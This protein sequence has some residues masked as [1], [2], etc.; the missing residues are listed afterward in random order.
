MKKLLTL[1]LCVLLM[2]ALAA[3]G[4]AGSGAEDEE[5]A[6]ATATDLETAEEYVADPAETADNE[7]YLTDYAEAAGRL[8]LPAFN[9]PKDMDLYRVLLVDEDKV[10]V[11]FYYNEKLYLGQFITGLA[12][13]PSGLSGLFENT[14]TAELSGESVTFEYPTIDPEN[15]PAPEQAGSKNHALAQTYDAE[16]NI[17]AWLVDNGYTDLDE[18][19]AAAGQFLDCLD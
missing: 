5:G 11:E 15:A 2:L 8:G 18:F 6:S 14:E 4:G 1:L 16:K 10:Q 12:E 13:N 3:C 19:K 9:I 7:T 17:T